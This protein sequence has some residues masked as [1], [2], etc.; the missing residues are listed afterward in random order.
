MFNLDYY[1]PVTRSESREVLKQ[2]FVDERSAVI[3]ITTDREQNLSLHQR[4]REN[5]CTAI[6]TC[7]RVEG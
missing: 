7:T 3:E 4:L 6:D 5:A 1:Q 2:C